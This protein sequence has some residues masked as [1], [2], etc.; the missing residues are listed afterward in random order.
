M[1]IV[2]KEVPPP[3]T[4]SSSDL[5]STSL[6]AKKLKLIANNSDA[7]SVNEGSINS[8]KVHDV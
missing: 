1:P 7:S 4:S 2:N 5:P 6:S 3:S 8:I